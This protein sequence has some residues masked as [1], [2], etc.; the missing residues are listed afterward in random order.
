MSKYYFHRLFTAMIGQ[1]LSQYIMNRRLNHSLKLMADENLSLTDISY[2]LGFSN[3]SAFIR[4]FKKAYGQT[5]NH[6]RKGPFEQLIAPIPELVQRPLKNLNGDIITDFTLKD[7]SL[8]GL[9]G[10]VF[11]VDLG[12]KDFKDN[13]RNQADKLLEKTSLP[14]NTPAYMIYSGCRP[15]S[16]VFNALFGLAVDFET[17]LPNVYTIDIPPTFSAGFKYKGD[18]LEISDIF[19][20]DFS[21]FLKLSRLQATGHDIE[22]IQMF[23]SYKDLY[24]NFEVYVPI[25][26]TQE[27]DNL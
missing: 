5:P 13:I 21:R 2:T 23:P 10:L 24:D 25:V 19:T 20:T 8:K 12:K 11:E 9:K 27:E 14:E 3:Q 17:N 4:N 18:L 1:P 7:F 22:L 6:I 26:K 15:G 16:S